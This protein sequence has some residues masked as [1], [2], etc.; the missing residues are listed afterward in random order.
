MIAVGIAAL[1][2][3]CAFL[4]E[5]GCDLTELS[6]GED[7]LLLLDEIAHRGGLG[8]QLVKLRL[9]K[10]CGTAGDRLFVAD[11][12]VHKLRRDRRGQGL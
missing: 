7:V 6:I 9:Q 4:E 5:L 8:A 11:D 3:L 12:L 1:L 10:V 2:F